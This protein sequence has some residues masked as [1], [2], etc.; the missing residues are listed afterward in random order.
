ML[1]TNV[2]GTAHPGG[3]SIDKLQALLEK[4][5]PI[6]AQAWWRDDIDRR[7][8][9]AWDLKFAYPALFSGTDLLR[10]FIEASP[11]EGSRSASECNYR[12]PLQSIRC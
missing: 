5:I 2:P 10:L 6:P 7:L 8:D 4:Q 9:D 3:G 1:V 11:S 12:I